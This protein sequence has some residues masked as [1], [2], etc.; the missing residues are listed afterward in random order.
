MLPRITSASVSGKKLFVTGEN[1]DLGAEIIL[2]D[3]K[4]KRVSNDVQ[5]PTTLLVARKAGKQIAAG[6]TV[7][8]QVRNSDG[9]QSEVFSFMRPTGN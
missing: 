9:R 2:N 8:L 1:F 6:D 7:R 3:K 5:N 4:Q